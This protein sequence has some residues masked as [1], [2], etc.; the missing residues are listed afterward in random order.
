MKAAENILISIRN[1]MSEKGVGVAYEALIKLDK[2]VVRD[3]SLEDK[4]SYYIL[5]SKCLLR[6]G[7]IRAALLKAR[8][9]LRILRGSH[10]DTLYAY[11]KYILGAILLDYG[12]LDRAAEEYN[13]AYVYY[14]RLANSDKVALTLSRLAHVY[15]LK[16]QLNRSYDY[17]A[18]GRDLCKRTGETNY[19]A[20]ILNNMCKIAISMGRFSEVE[21]VLIECER[22]VCVDDRRIHAIISCAHSSVLK[23]DLEAASKY[24]EQAAI[25]STR[26]NSATH[27]IIVN[28]YSGLFEHYSGNYSKAREYYQRVLDMPEPTASAVAQTL[29][30]LTDVCI[31]EGNYVEAMAIAKKAEKATTKINERIELGALYRA[32]GQI[33]THRGKHQ[34]ACDYFSKSITLLRE[35]GAR[36]ELALT[37][38]ACGESKSYDYKTRK[39]Y[40][41][42][43]R[44]LFDEMDVPK[45]V[46]QVQEA[47]EK[48]KL[49][50][51]PDVIV[52]SEDTAPIIIAVNQEMK[53]IV[54]FSQEV[55]KSSLNILLTGETGTGKDLFARYIHSISNRCG[56]FVP[57]NAGTIPQEMIES[58][59]FGYNKG[60]FTGA[61][62]SRAGLFEAA[63][64]GTFYLNEIADA[65]A[66]FQIKLLEVL[67]THKVRRLGENK[68]RSVNFRLIAATNRDLKQEINGGRFRLDLYHRLNEL[69]VVLPPLRERQDEV[70]ALVTHFL[71]Q[72]SS[73]IAADGRKRYISALSNILSSG[74]WSGNVRELRAEINRLWVESRRDIIKMVSV[75]KTNQYL[76]IKEDL[77][78]TLEETGW[79]RRE[80]ARRLDISE[81]TVRYRIKKYKLR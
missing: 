73:D 72:L 45:R 79:N 40:L 64:E 21:D 3:F 76:R 70:N 1:L 51:I 31:A 29:R 16:G 54:A 6:I 52:P 10:N 35:I 57:V 78:S 48:L 13:E 25:V 39:R 4:F 58:E 50:T 61:S 55:A 53:K 60:A 71:C 41:E 67:E 66:P 68:R 65:P 32:Y 77:I 7:E 22:Y 11:A 59:L 15:Y 46:E 62:K 20:S 5:Q 8:V 23:C 74:K 36:Y 28:E 30:M 9:A 47:I 80:A 49:E 33:Y 42:S 19:L 63:D 18:K 69:S 12:Q 81:T 37:Y 38:F 75:A 14:K 27:S 2:S 43:A 24:L 34:I 56:E 26:T 44:L 17:L